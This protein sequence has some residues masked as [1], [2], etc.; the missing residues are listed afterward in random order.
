MPLT[1]NSLTVVFLLM[2]FSLSS[3]PV[4]AQDQA[5][6]LGSIQ[7]VI[8]GYDGMPLPGANVWALP[9][10]DMR[11]PISTTSDAAGMF[12]L[13]NIPIG[14]VYVL[15]F[16]ESEGYPYEFYAFYK[17]KNDRSSAKV[18]AKA[19]AVT[20]GVTIQLGPKAAYLKVNAT[21]EK[22]VPVQVGY[23]LDRDDMPGPFSTSVPTD[24]RLVGVG[25]IKGIM[26]VPPV[27][28]RLTVVADGYEPWHY[29]GANWQGKAGL[30]TLKSG[31][32]L[33]LDVRLRKKQESK[34]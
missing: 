22:G 27:P 28:F 2:V 34:P 17:T 25:F 4:A 13:R 8:L 30:I 16:K 5:V 7:G 9:E 18:E 6:T 11:Y 33:S 15:G 3:L 31:E 10:Q 21:D 1:K 20:S 14:S 23:Q 32:T 24:P 29:G 26:L 12:I 19:G